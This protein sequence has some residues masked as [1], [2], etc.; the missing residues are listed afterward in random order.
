MNIFTTP[1][2][3]GAIPEPPCDNPMSGAEHCHHLSATH[4][5]RKKW[6]TSLS[7]KAMGPRAAAGGKCAVQGA[8][9]PVRNAGKATDHLAL[10][11]EPG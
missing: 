1:G 10:D 6:R 5:E 3:P 11:S 2:I 8:G 9:D 4:I 7:P